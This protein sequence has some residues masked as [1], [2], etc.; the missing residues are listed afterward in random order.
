MSTAV[1]SQR[2]YSDG[3]E[4]IFR[5]PNVLTAIDSITVPGIRPASQRRAAKT[6]K[7]EA[8]A[9]E[10][11]QLDYFDP[12]VME[13]LLSPLL[14]PPATPGAS[15][16]TFTMRGEVLDVESVNAVA[17]EGGIL[18]ALSSDSLSIL[19]LA[20][21]DRP[22]LLGALALDGVFAS[23]LEIRGRCAYVLQ[24][25]KLLVVDVG[26]SAA[27]K[28]LSTYD[29]RWPQGSYMDVEIGTLDGHLMAYIA[30]G[31][32][33]E[34]IGDS[35]YWP[36]E[37]LALDLSAPYAI[38]QVANMNAYGWPV[39]LKVDGP[40]LYVGLSTG[41]HGNVGGYYRIH[42]SE[43]EWAGED[44]STELPESVLA[45]ET[46][47]AYVYLGT[48][49]WGSGSI[50]VIDVRDPERA[51]EVGA[52][53]YGGT[54][55]LLRVGATLFGGTG[56]G[57]VAF[58]LSNP[59]E[60]VEV[61][62]LADVAFG[63]MA[64]A[65]GRLYVAE[66]DELTIVDVGP[67]GVVAAGLALDDT[68]RRMDADAAATEAG[69]AS[70]SGDE[71]GDEVNA[72]ETAELR[73]LVENLNIRA[74]PGTR[75]PV[76]EQV[77]EGQVLSVLGRNAQGSWLA[78]C[79]AAGQQ[80]WVILDPEYVQ[81]GGDVAFLPVQAE[82]AASEPASSEPAQTP[83]DEAVTCSVA[84]AGGLEDMRVAGG[85]GC[86]RGASSITWAAYTPF[87]GG[88]VLWR[89]DTQQIYGFFADGTWRAVPDSWNGSSPTP[90]R[91]SPP[92]GRLEPVRG[93]GWVWGTDDDFF[94]HLGWATGEQT[95]FCAEVQ[96]FEEGFVLRS[97]TTPQCDAENANPVQSANFLYLAPAT[98]APGCVDKEGAGV[99][100]I[101]RSQ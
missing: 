56:E 80:G 15:T 38:H 100:G 48:N 45:F 58:D 63:D 28:I 22:K 89:R 84:A 19:S 46:A 27:P 97:S 67:F 3:Y 10:Q 52:L 40:H 93:A 88:F 6:A 55:N 13:E 34:N 4:A 64:Y 70:G 57:L 60:P 66:W 42:F 101:R 72:V 5:L 41:K 14:T 75:Y 43:Y 86:A 85:L 1:A 29:I 35:G 30:D 77:G 44:I 20:D 53:D 91:G 76:L 32:D 25:N 31:G 81:Y 59:A 2:L 96:V 47:G 50:R 16:G 61:G 90:S 54:A 92:P 17:A 83:V 24:S 69:D 68:G 33:S 98:A 11:Q 37:I 78:V 73:V 65:A 49:Y 39:A 87:E 26:D 99:T 74:G 95:G 21:P 62:R 71:V 23:D 94:S 9:W 18:Y 51:A 12:A 79:C 82:E 36:G 7:A 8:E